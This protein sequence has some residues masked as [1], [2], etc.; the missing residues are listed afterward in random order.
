MVELHIDSHVVEFTLPTK[1]HIDTSQKTDVLIFTAVE[2]SNRLPASNVF[3][4]YLLE[5]PAEYTL[6]MLNIREA[7]SNVAQGGWANV[8]MLVDETGISEQLTLRTHSARDWFNGFM[9][10]TVTFP[11]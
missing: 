8:R 9:S 3:P 11:V 1:Q 6:R 5:V 2:S 7:P 4:V 10:S